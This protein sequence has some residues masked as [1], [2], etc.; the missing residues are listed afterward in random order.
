M[1]TINNDLTVYG[2]GSG[3]QL[4]RINSMNSLKYVMAFVLQRCIFVYF[5]C[6]YFFFNSVLV[7]KKQ[8]RYKQN[9]QSLKF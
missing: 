9:F 8:I 5:G 4:I 2:S 3:F 7:N 6:T 1:V